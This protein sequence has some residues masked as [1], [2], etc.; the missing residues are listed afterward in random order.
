MNDTKPNLYDSK[1]LKII[2]ISEHTYQHISYLES[3]SFG[4]VACNGLI[5]A[6]AGE[7]GYI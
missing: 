6:D 1:T 7:A 5:V 2:Q 4:R 3:P